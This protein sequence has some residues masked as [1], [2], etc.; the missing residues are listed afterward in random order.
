MYIRI[1]YCT[2]FN[3]QNSSNKIQ[4]I[5]KTIEYDRIHGYEHRAPIKR[6]KKQVQSN[7]EEKEKKCLINVNQVSNVE[8]GENNVV[9]LED[10]RDK[11]KIRTQSFDELDKNKILNIFKN[12]Q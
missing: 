3:A 2:N 6:E 9:V 4:E 1:I 5:W 7:E 8:C 11:L 12:N 10:S